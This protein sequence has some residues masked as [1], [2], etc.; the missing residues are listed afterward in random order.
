MTTQPADIRR[1]GQVAGICSFAVAAIFVFQEFVLRLAPGP[2]TTDE[3]LA[4][5][6]TSIERARMGAMFLLFFLALFTYAGIAFRA[7]NSMARAALVFGAL[8]CAIELTY[9]A[10]EMGAAPQWADGYRQAHDV[11]TQSL[12]RSRIEVF[13]DVIAALYILIRGAAIATSLCFG[14][15]L[16]RATGLQRGVSLFFFANAVRLLLSYAKPLVPGLEPVLDWV[17]V[18]VLVPLYVC[19]G[20]W[21]RSDPAPT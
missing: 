3:W 20:L 11:V 17:F 6:L 19:A 7:G 10:V 14:T 2:S 4:A 13:Q 16:W 21:L 8:G 12:Y 5:P 1:F 18:A 15:A 9:R